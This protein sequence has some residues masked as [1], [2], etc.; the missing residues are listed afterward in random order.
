MTAAARGGGSQ[1][2]LPQLDS[3]FSDTICT[4]G[5]ID[6]HCRLLSIKRFDAHMNDVTR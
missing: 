1:K 5:L 2:S 4:T 3:D 6:I